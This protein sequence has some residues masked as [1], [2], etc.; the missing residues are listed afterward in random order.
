MPELGRPDCEA[1]VR[2]I[3]FNSMTW[4]LMN[5]SHAEISHTLEA[6]LD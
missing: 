6:K 2:V 3:L 4:R 1:V 5:Q